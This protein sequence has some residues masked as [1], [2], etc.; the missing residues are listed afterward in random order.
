MSTQEY[1]R[2]SYTLLFLSILFFQFGCTTKEE[3]KYEQIIEINFEDKKETDSKQTKIIN[4]PTIIKIF[5]DISDYD[6]AEIIKDTQEYYNLSDFQ[7]YY[8]HITPLIDSLKINSIPLE[9]KN[10]ELNFKTQNG[11]FYT[12]KP[13]KLPTEQGLILFNG[14]NKPIFWKGNDYDKL[15]IFITEY[16]K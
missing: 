7:T 16:F 10:V 6:D 12:L 13:L 2:Y 1:F 14:K 3:I 8:G 15:D 9:E 4:N 11:D 5:I